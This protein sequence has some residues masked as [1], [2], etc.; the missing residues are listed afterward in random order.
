MMVMTWTTCKWFCMSMSGSILYDMV[1]T[2]CL[3]GLTLELSS[4]RLTSR[5]GH[6]FTQNKTGRKRRESTFK[7]S[8]YSSPQ[9]KTAQARNSNARGR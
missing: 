8:H 3:A 2:L 1:D 6:E 9:R 4:F 5:V 7:L